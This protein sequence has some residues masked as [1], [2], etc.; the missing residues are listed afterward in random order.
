FRVRVTLL[1]F[2]QGDEHADPANPLE[3]A[4]ARGPFLPASS[5]RAS[6]R[7]FVSVFDG[8]TRRPMWPIEDRPVPASSVRGEKAAAVQPHPDDQRRSIF[9][10]CAR[11]VRT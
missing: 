9:R 1:L 10:V 2:A 3:L 5:L 6:K 11:R 8:V 7:A 4:V